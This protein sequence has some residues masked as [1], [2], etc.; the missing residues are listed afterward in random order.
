MWDIIKQPG[1]CNWSPWRKREVFEEVTLQKFPNLIKSINPQ[2]QAVPKSTSRVNTKKIIPKH[3][4]AKLPKNKNEEKILKGV[5]KKNTP[6]R[7]I[8]IGTMLRINI[9]FS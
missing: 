5:K 9:V 3:I 2:I 6:Q 7:Y 8:Y 4:T 1:L